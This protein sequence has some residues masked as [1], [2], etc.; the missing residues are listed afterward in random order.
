MEDLLLKAG[1]YAIINKR[2]N[3]VYVGETEACFLI[4]WIEHVSR[5]SKF[6]DERDKALLY[7]DKHTEY[8]VLKELDPIQVSRKEFYRY[9]EEATLFYK[10]K[11]WVV[12]SKANY[13]PL[14]HEVIYQDTE[15]IIKRYKKAIKHMIKI[16]GLK[17]TKENN[18]GRLYTALYKKLNRHFDTDVWERAETN[19]I[20]TLTKEELEFILLDLF[21]RYREKKLNLDR[22]EYKKMDRQLSLFE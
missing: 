9:E 22:E 17:N 20:D 11:R 15:G 3:T 10:N 13:S 14:M 18:V 16:L 21:P 1:V 4:R 5:V 7:L 2:L 12:I 6:L 19:I 8:I